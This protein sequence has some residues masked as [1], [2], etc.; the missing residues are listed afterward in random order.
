M[1]RSFG[2]KDTGK[3]WHEQC[4][5][6]VD[7]TV[8]RVTLRK[9]ELVDA[10]KDVGELRIL[11]AIICITADMAIRLARYF[12]TSEEFWMSLQSNFELR[13]ERRALPDKVEGP[14]VGDATP[15][16][17]TLMSVRGACLGVG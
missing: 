1:I 6:G 8:Q 9:L 15:S 4:V 10:A 11:R 7:R 2:S 5:K 3:I 14:L 17:V 16:F 13:R 12:R